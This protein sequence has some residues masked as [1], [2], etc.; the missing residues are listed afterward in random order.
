MKRVPAGRKCAAAFRRTFA[1]DRGEDTRSCR[2]LRQSSHETF[3]PGYGGPRGSHDH[4]IRT[5]RT[6]RRGRPLTPDVIDVLSR[7]TPQGPLYKATESIVDAIDGLAE[8]V[9]GDRRRFHQRD[10]TTPGRICRPG[11]GA[12]WSSA[13][14]TKAP[15]SGRS[16]PIDAVTQESRPIKTVNIAVSG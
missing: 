9:T 6:P 1:S 8:V 11:N 10:A 16:W 14:V 5:A 3:D 2:Y 7:A 13:L 15:V 12:R 4:R